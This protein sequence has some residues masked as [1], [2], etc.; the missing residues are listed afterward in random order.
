MKKKHVIKKKSF[1][2]FCE[3]N[4]L[5]HVVSAQLRTLGG[6]VVALVGESNINFFDVQRQAMNY[7]D[8]VMVL[9]FFVCN[10][11]KPPKNC[12]GVGD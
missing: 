1:R 5:E 8:H 3:L 7:G 10:S 2:K 12:G 4:Q 6:F 9:N 11:T